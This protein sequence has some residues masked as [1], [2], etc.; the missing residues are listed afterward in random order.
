M[1]PVAS[2]LVGI[3]TRVDRKLEKSTPKIR[4]LVADLLSRPL[5]RLPGDHEPPA[6]PTTALQDSFYHI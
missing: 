1:L 5:S 2:N 4:E 6:L 3:D